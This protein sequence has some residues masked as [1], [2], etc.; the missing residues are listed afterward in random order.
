MFKPVDVSLYNFYF[1]FLPQSN[2]SASASCISSFVHLTRNFIACLQRVFVKQLNNT[3][4]K[5]TYRPN[6][7][8]PGSLVTC[9]S[10]HPLALYEDVSAAFGIFIY[11]LQSTC[12]TDIQ[13][14]DP[15]KLK[16]LL[17]LL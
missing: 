5:V 1:T 17:L 10:A 4:F 2:L 13:A 15:L 14:K 6:L 9:G 3:N 7:F 12:S 8:P 16:D 11:A